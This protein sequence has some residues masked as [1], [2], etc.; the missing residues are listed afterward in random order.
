MDRWK[1]ILKQLRA[2][3]Y[4]GTDDDI[5]AV[6]K[7]LAGENE[8]GETITLSDANG[9][10]DIEAAFKA[11]K[12]P[13]AKAVTI[14]DDESEE[15]ESDDKVDYK[16]KYLQAE[17]RANGHGEWA[18]Q[19]SER[20]TEKK[21]LTNWSFTPRGVL[22]ARLEKA[23]NR[24][25][26][27]ND[28][29]ANFSD[30]E[31]AA[32]FGAFIRLA[33]FGKRDY[34]QKSRDKE[35]CHKLQSTHDDASGGITVPDDFDPSLFRL[36]EKVGGGHM[37][38]EQV[39]MARDKVVRPRRTSGLSVMTPGEG[40][41]I[42]GSSMAFDS[43]ELVASK[44]AGYAEFTSEMF[45]DSAINIADVLGE[46]GIYALESDLENAYINGDGTSTYWGVVGLGQRFQDVLTAGG[47]TWAT[48]ADK[49]AS[50]TVGSGNLW[51]ELVQADFDDVIGRQ[52]D[53]DIPYTQTWLCG[54][55]F[56]D[57]VINPRIRAAGGAVYEIFQGLPSA[58]FNGGNIVTSTKMPRFQ[59]NSQFCAFYGDFRLASAVGRVRGSLSV[60]TSDQVGFLKDT[61]YIRFMHRA[62]I[63]VHDVGNYSATAASRVFGPIVGLLTAAS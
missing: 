50:V 63:C 34:A 25:I 4:K 17:A 30:A 8:E 12:K 38:A 58:T 46:E 9:K 55:R 37:L 13:K 43:Y 54:K 15:D 53:Y 3:G 60:A 62:A 31:E 49:L 19:E 52:N 41:T 26:S 10:V 22:E 28:P 39:S 48:D 6:K 16:A 29:K 35:I 11:A 59:A 7:F 44:R 36:R 5:E 61:I 32:A 57:T 24:R 21:G 14:E 2:L 45:N 1:K 33:A 47:G 23:Y 27:A 56:K 51:S 18:S 20:E 40:G 42:T